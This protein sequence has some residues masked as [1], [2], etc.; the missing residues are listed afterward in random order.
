MPRLS[1]IYDSILDC[2][3]RIMSEYKWMM[4]IISTT[5]IHH[6]IF[7]LIYS[8]IIY[9]FWFRILDDIYTFY[10]KKFMFKFRYKFININSGFF[11]C[12]PYI[13][14]RSFMQSCY[15]VFSN[16]FNIWHDQPRIYFSEC[17]YQWS[18]SYCCTII[19]IIIIILI[20]IYKV[21]EV[22][23]IILFTVIKHLHQWVYRIIFNKSFW[24]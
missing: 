15:E 24:I 16:R 22:N 13:W 19:F 18:D 3:W 4:R 21:I 9:S 8:E 7:M 5:H 20:S 12:I 1:N 2:Y 14:V 11:T 17:S 23:I 6:C 10:L